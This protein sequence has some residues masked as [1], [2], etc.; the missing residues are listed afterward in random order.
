MSHIH[1][2]L[3]IFLDYSSVMPSVIVVDELSIGSKFETEQVLC[4]RLSALF[5]F[6]LSAQRHLNFSVS[7]HLNFLFFCVFFTATLVSDIA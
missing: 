2:L 6:S 3:T 1:V 4:I 7:D 5:F